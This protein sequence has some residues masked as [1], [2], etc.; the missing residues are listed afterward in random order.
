MNIILIGMMGSGKSTLG[1]VLADL[2]D[3]EFIDTDSLIETSQ[4]M[5]ISQIFDI[6]GEAF[7]RGLETE[8]IGKISRKTA[9]V[10]ALGGGAVMRP[11]NMILQGFTVYLRC[12]ADI[13]ADRIAETN[14]RPLA[15]KMME[16]LAERDEL[17]KRYSNFVVDTQESISQVSEQILDEYSNNKRT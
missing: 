5:P 1:R 10:I 8:V 11:Q 9:S 2:T 4:K 15:S 3:M 14:T 16:L 7:F 13:L 6:Y 17:Y 12:N